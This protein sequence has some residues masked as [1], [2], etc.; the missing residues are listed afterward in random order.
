MQKIG[1]KAYSKL[2]GKSDKTVYKMIKEGL[3]AAKKGNNGYEVA[4]DGYV[5]ERY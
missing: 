4:V 2:I 3:N 1:L 5:L